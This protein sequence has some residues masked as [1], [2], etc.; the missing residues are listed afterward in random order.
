[1]TNPDKLIL[2]DVTPYTG[3]FADNVVRIALDIGEGMLKS[4]A[5][6]HRVEVAIDK[7]C[8][9]YGAAHVD[10]FTIQS[11]ILTAV[12][13]PDGSHSTQSRRIFT[14]STNLT[15][16]EEYNALS[17]QICAEKLSIDEVDARIR[18][19]KQK[20]AYPLPIIVLG[21]MLGAGSFAVFFGGTLR[22]GV[23]AAVIGIAV[24]L[25]NAVNFESFNRMIKTLLIS[26]VSG[27]LSCLAV[28]CGLGENLDM[29]LI[30]EIM[31][32]IPGLSLGNA[33][34]DLLWGDTL[35]GSSKVVQA[36]V[37]AVMIAVGLAL[38][39]LIA[40]GGL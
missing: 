21:N 26:L 18:Q 22:D 31:L 39:L 28:R 7:I 30:G 25:L 9:A 36:V 14:I 35:T 1:M 20:S 32:M 4:D 16:I 13:M 8:R 15:R 6:V 27:L 17:R 24:A 37:V 23:A 29:I 2:P 33:M 3:S 19:I 40:G 38:A 34:R 11:L 10:V 12:Y 5:E